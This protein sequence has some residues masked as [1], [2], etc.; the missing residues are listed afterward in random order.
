MHLFDDDCLTLNQE[1]PSMGRSFKTNSILDSNSFTED[2]SQLYVH[3]MVFVD[4]L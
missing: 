1:R 4:D 2:L 3:S